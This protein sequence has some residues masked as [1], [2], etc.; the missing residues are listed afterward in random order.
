MQMR[1]KDREITNT[2]EILEIINKCKVCRIGMI[3]EGKPYIV[4]LNFGYSYNGGDFELYFHS[5]LKGR[6]FEVI[7][8]NP[9][10][11]IE[12][13]CNHQLVEEE[14][15]CKNGYL[16]ASIIGEGEAVFIEDI[17]AKKVALNAM[18]KHIVGKEFEFEDKMTESVAVFKVKL[19][20]MSAK[21]RRV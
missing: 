11:C 5:A 1:R 18:M 14:V 16:Y 15:P 9:T 10:V 2:E 13:D 7:R 3:D 17:A 8:K 6:K 12:M 20:S 21:A 4:P 19:T